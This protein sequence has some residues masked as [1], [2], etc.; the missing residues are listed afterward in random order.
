MEEQMQKSNTT[1]QSSES[2]A[3][4]V[5]QDSFLNSEL[6]PDINARAAVRRNLFS[7]MA[8]IAT[9]GAS[10]LGAALGCFEFPSAQVAAKEPIAASAGTLLEPKNITKLSTSWQQVLTVISEVAEDITSSLLREVNLDRSFIE[11]ENA[12]FLAEE[13]A[14]LTIKGDVYLS[15]K[16]FEQHGVSVKDRIKLGKLTAQIDAHGNISVDPRTGDELKKTALSIIGS[17]GLFDQAIS[18]GLKTVEQA[19]GFVAIENTEI[20][21]EEA[22]GQVKIAGDI[23]LL[24]KAF[25]A[26]DIAVSDKIKLGRITGQIGHDG[27]LA[28]EEASMAELRQAALTAISSSTLVTKFS[29]E[30]L[31]AFKQLESYLSVETLLSLTTVR[32]QG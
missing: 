23:Y 18:S 3:E 27:K 22:S 26:L 17:K 4:S 24:P 19:E 15:P 16:F 31:G 32:E 7:D 14:G 13:R 30:Y 6:F 25:E 1:Y 28:F 9:L 8:K 2:H 29:K 21:L 11:F 12:S 20:T 5:I 10:G